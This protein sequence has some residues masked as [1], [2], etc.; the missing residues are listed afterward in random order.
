LRYSWQLL[1]AFVLSVLIHALLGFYLERTPWA[2]GTD[3]LYPLGD[4]M[5]DV[6]M[7]PDS[8]AFFE[9]T[10]AGGEPVYE[11]N[12]RKTLQQQVDQ[13]PNLPAIPQEEWFSP[14]PLAIPGPQD[15]LLAHADSEISNIPGELD[16]QQLAPEIIKVAEP[17]VEA[18][19][20]DSRVWAPEPVDGPPPAVKVEA[21]L[22]PASVH[23]S[24]NL[25]LVPVKTGV[26]PPPLEQLADL[27]PPPPP[28]PPE[29]PPELVSSTLPENDQQPPELPEERTEFK[30]WDDL[31]D[32]EITTYRPDPAGGSRT[33]RTAGFFKAVVK[34]NEEAAKMRVMSKDVML[35][36]DVSGSMAGPVFEGLRQGLA[37]AL[38]MLKQGDRFGVITFGSE[39]TFLSDHLWPVTPKNIEEARQ[40]IQRQKAEGVTDIYR[41]VATVIRSLPDS[42]RP[43]LI[44]LC[45]DG[46]PT[47]GIQDSREII[48]ALSV[49]NRLRAAIHVFG[50]GETLNRP[51][52]RLLAYRNKGIAHFIETS[53]SGK[54]RNHV[55]SE[56]IPSQLVEMIRQLADPLLTGIQVDLS[57]MTEEEAYPLVLPDLY[58]GSWIEFYGRYDREKEI[59]VRLTGNVRGKL[60]EFVFRGDLPKA[61]P[62]QRSIAQAWAAAKVFHLVSQN[63][64]LGETEVRLGAIKDLVKTYQL[65]LPNR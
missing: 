1:T 62:T 43:F 55:G 51:L 23:D 11:E 56:K 6:R 15:D 49:V 2:P 52:L 50:V 31:L 7:I 48:N 58:L 35:A 17:L 30:A 10:G 63:L 45:T 46:R 13:A 4:R 47:I 20:P 61:D 26:I 53:D 36:L 27:P 38:S 25:P 9:D 54:N 41:S 64:E 37:E 24:L 19:Q 5:I 18:P 60:K 16:Q 29:I 59:A 8:P 12:L 32:V 28:L 22:F 40:F 44:F 39:L 14:E 65:D 33:A 21:P 34:P 42:D 57:G 3:N